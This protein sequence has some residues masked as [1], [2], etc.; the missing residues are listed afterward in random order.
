MTRAY[1]L[2][3]S[4]VLIL[5]SKH[6]SK[7]ELLNHRLPKRQLKVIK[8]N[9]NGGHVN[10]KK[11]KFQ[12]RNG[13]I[14]SVLLIVIMFAEAFNGKY[15]FAKE[16]MCFTS[17]PSCSSTSCCWFGTM[18][19]ASLTGESGG[20]FSRPYFRLKCDGDRRCCFFVNIAAPATQ[21]GTSPQLKALK[22]R[23]GWNG[24]NSD[25]NFYLQMSR[26]SREESNKATSLICIHTF[27]FTTLWIHLVCNYFY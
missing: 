9:N 19:T 27:I 5:S 12:L 15:P 14:F 6:F 17:S 13:A 25:R 8:S 2:N 23:S 26:A 24:S 16:K 7:T 20:E 11:K 4:E 1:Y 22:R 21:N 18:G 3:L 10:K